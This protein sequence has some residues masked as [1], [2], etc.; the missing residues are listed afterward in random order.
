MNPWRAKLEAKRWGGAY[1][2]DLV[3]LEDAMAVVEE[4]ERVTGVEIRREIDD[5]IYVETSLHDIIRELRRR[6]SVTEAALKVQTEL[7]ERAIAASD[8]NADLCQTMRRERDALRAEVEEANKSAQE[9]EDL[10]DLHQECAAKEGDELR[11][12]RAEVEGLRVMDR[13]VCL[14]CDELTESTQAAHDEATELR[15]QLATAHDAI[16]QTLDLL[17]S[18]RKAHSKGSP[19]YDALFIRCEVGGVLEDALKKNKGGGA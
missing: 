11:A 18:S 6:L 3:S 13:Q 16:Q 2:Q 12:L 7:N 4:V 1:G 14:T 10:V 15:A 8:H 19:E 9:F 5:A 17:E